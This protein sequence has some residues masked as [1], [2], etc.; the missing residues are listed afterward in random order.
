MRGGAWVHKMVLLACLKERMVLMNFH[1]PE[2]VVSAGSPEE[3]EKLLSAGA[4]AV[5]VGDGRYALRVPGNL[6][7][8]MITDVGR[9]AHGQGKKVYVAL[10]ALL[11]QEELNGLDEY[12]R[13]LAQS[14]VDAVVFGD[15]AV[16]VAVQKTAPGLKRHWSTET[17]STNWRTV[18]FWARKGA[19]RAILARELSLEEVIGVKQ[20]S[21]IP[22]QVQVHGMT[23]IFHSKRPLV[24]NYLHI[25]GKGD[26]KQE[27]L[28]VLKENTRSGQHY[29][30]IEDHNGTHVM[31]HEDICML[32]HLGVLIENGID[33]FYIE[34]LGKPLSY[35]CQVVSVYR[36][37]IDCLAKN[38]Q[39]ALDPALL[40]AINAVQPTERPI[41][42]GFYF[43][44][45]VY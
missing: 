41:G 26:N 11:H 25:L 24:S 2:L 18:N 32:E 14:K 28:M 23:C 6:S 20:Q 7:M 22:V 17:T 36:Q 31:S 40:D 10:N 3:A 30:I 34:A 4:D 27:Q 43:R 12:V 35:N 37:A 33:S 44:E 45:Q 42:T 39:A 1:T 38:P 5:T 29:P 19:S 13:Q 21:R 8:P 15:P 9:I 16:L